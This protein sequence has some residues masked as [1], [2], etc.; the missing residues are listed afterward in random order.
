MR[1][2]D[3]PLLILASLSSGAKHGYALM[4]DIEEF[5][6]VRL[7]P[8]SLYGAIGRLEERGLIRPLQ[9]TGRSRP[10]ALTAAGRRELAEVV[11]E[12][13]TLVS[14]VGVRLPRLSARGAV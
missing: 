12:M 14:L 11:A 5:A 8:G 4:Q 9:P 2:S 10:Y 7:G 6:G 1:S 3:P 13:R